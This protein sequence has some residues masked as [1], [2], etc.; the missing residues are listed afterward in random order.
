MPGEPHAFGSQPVD[1]GRAQPLLPITPQ[2][3]PSEVIRQ[4]EDN[5]GRRGSLC[6]ERP[7]TRDTHH[8]RDP[9]PSQRP[10]THRVAPPS[11]GTVPDFWSFK[12]FGAIT[13]WQ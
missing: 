6:S 4:D 13:A 11:F 5:V 12:S 10:P 3:A 2:L 1:V 7:T 9:Q 8:H